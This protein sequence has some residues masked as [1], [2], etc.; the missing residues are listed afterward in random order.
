MQKGKIKNILKKEIKRKLAELRKLVKKKERNE[1]K[2][3]KYTGMNRP[4]SNHISYDEDKNKKLIN[5]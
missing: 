5:S 3:G 2:I 1:G 4:Y